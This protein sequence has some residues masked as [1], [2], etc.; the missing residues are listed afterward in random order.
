M[1]MRALTFALVCAMAACGGDDAASDADDTTSD[2]LDAVDADDLVDDSADDITDDPSDDTPI[3]A[4]PTD[5]VRSAGCDQAT[6]QAAGSYVE[7]PIAA[8]GADR[9]AF[10]RLPT[11]YDPAVAYPVVY[12]LHGCSN[13][14]NRE[15]NIVSLESQANNTV[16][17]VKGRAAQ[18]CWDTGG[19]SVD[20]P[21]FDAL[22]ADVEAAFCIDTTKR[23]LTGY[24]SGSFMTHRLACI[25]GELF[26]GVASI[27]GGQ[28]GNNCTGN[29]AALLI[30]DLN[31][32]TVNISASEAT[33]DNHLERNSCTSPP[34]S[35]PTDHPP[36]V[37]YAGCA[38]PVVWCQTTGRGH[39]RQDAVAA[40]IFW[41]FL[42]SL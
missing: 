39:D 5:P 15:N 8:G 38:K 40:P 19:T 33:R 36:C 24:S 3:D 42:S 1:G 32:P 18:D 12:Q 13:S 35:T 21:Y 11:G 37:E 10:V 22:V 14:A 20:V 28:P 9:S 16:I 17:L 31:D 25:R 6:S 4:A 26:R 30:H 29:T 2:S 27:A 34:S 7:R 23:F 41:S